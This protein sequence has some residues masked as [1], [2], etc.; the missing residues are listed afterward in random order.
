MDNK[1]E[2]KEATIIEGDDKRSFKVE[3]ILTLILGVLLGFT[4]K[5]EALKRVTIGFNDYQLKNSVG[6]FNI[7]EAE[8][9]LIEEAEQNAQQEGDEQINSGANCSI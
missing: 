1:N 8:R 5:T 4:I 6:A 2:I 9:K 3:I 7:S